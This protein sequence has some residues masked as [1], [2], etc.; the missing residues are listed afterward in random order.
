VRA[1]RCWTR[2]WSGSPTRTRRPASRSPG[3]PPTARKRE[4][5][6]GTPSRRE[7]RPSFNGCE[8]N[9]QPADTVTPSVPGHL[10]PAQDRNDLVPLP[11]LPQQPH[12]FPPGAY[13]TGITA[14]AGIAARPGPAGGDPARQLAAGAGRIRYALSEA[15][16]NGHCYLPEPNLLTDAAQILEV[17]PKLVRACVDELAASEGADRRGGAQPDHRGRED[18]WVPGPGRAEAGVRS[19]AD[20]QLADQPGPP[21]AWITGARTVSPARRPRPVQQSGVPHIA[22]EVRRVPDGTSR[23]IRDR[24]SAR[25]PAR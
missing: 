9:E 1:G 21:W 16:D 24:S 8:P 18:P 11:P 7:P 4:H 10:H 19:A 6:N 17:P 22:S 25:R 23:S 2:C 15:A 3:W 12:Q 20:G 14:P 5:E 13:V